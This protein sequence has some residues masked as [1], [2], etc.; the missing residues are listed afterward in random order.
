MKVGDVLTEI[1]NKLSRGTFVQ[2]VAT[3]TLCIEEKNNENIVGTLQ[4]LHIDDIPFNTKE[5]W[6]LNDLEDESG[7]LVLKNHKTPEAILCIADFD[8]NRLMVYFIEMKSE[9]NLDV[10]KSCYEKVK[11]ALD[12]VFILLI[13]NER[14]HQQVPRYQGL[15]IIFRSAVFYIEI[16]S[17]TQNLDKTRKLTQLNTQLNNPNCA[18]DTNIKRAFQQGIKT[19]VD[20]SNTFLGKQKV[21]TK[22][23][24]VP[25]GDT[26]FTITYE[27]LITNF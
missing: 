5:S 24:P 12:R 1:L 19:N 27:E 21:E 25:F 10:L 22:F 8:R 26:E 15:E 9:P 14:K 3:N 6:L 23:F 7:F 20:Y 18:L 2:N 4:K 11:H 16:A 17:Q 13:L